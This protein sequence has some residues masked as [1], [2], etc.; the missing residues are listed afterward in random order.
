MEI[1]EYIDYFAVTYSPEFVETLISI[2]K[3]F[4]IVNYDRHSDLINEIFELEGTDL[5][6]NIC[7][8]AIMVYRT[9]IADCLHK[10]GITLINAESDKLYMLA[11]I[12]RGVTLLATRPIMEITEGELVDEDEDDVSYLCAFLSIC[13]DV[14][15]VE[16][17]QYIASVDQVVIDVLHA[18]ENLDDV[19]VINNAAAQ[20]RF[21]KV[22][23]DDKTGI[24]IEAVRKLG[25][26]GYDFDTMLKVVEDDIEV[27]TDGNVIR[28]ELLLL[29]A[30]SS[31]RL[32]TVLKTK[33][34]DTV[35]SLFH[36][37]TLML[38]VNGKWP[39]M[40]DLEI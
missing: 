8:K 13:C 28:R 9:H 7:D 17:M 37:P 12:L 27:L 15:S 2:E 1:P 3:S 36:N 22:L 19:A 40:D 18:G 26:F 38:S 10:Q 33:L 14:P 4:Q 6:R 29:G 32:P 23:G 31:M 25:Y 39:N 24:V 16:L 30:G 5:L 11:T 21:L 35:E 34:E 20:S